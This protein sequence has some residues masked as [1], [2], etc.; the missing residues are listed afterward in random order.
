ME[1]NYLTLIV[2]TFEKI[3]TTPN[4]TFELRKQTMQDLIIGE[5]LRFEKT[6]QVSDNT[7]MNGCNEAINTLTS[8]IDDRI[9][10][11]KYK[12]DENSIFHILGKS[13]KNPPTSNQSV[14]YDT[15]AINVSS[16]VPNA[17]NTICFNDIKFIQSVFKNFGI[18]TSKDQELQDLPD[19]TLVQKIIYLN[20]LGI[21]DLLRKEPSFATSVNNLATVIS[22]ITGVKTSTVQPVLNALI[23]NANYSKNYPYN[24]DS[25]VIKVKNHLI[26]LG[27]KPK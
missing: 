21:I 22:A 20:E 9:K 19:T 4:L 1:P 17:K 14:N 27:V 3:Q 6:E 25:T 11:E 15:L 18:N 10:S 26:N 16:I 13:L 8:F 24:S 2:E 5:Q 12:N 7:F 23:N